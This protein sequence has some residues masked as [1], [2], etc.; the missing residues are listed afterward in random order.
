MSEKLRS[1]LAGGEE[2]VKPEAIETASSSA[3]RD[4]IAGHNS[5]LPAQSVGFKTSGFKSSFKAAKDPA[6]DPAERLLREVLGQQDGPDLDG[7]EMKD[8]NGDIDE[9]LDGECMED[10]DGEA[11]EDLDG[12]GM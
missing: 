3:Q 10:V 11:M 1:L 6:T 8:T 4:A 7:E 12:E 2:P 5:P 9:D